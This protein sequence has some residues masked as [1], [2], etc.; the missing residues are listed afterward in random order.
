VRSP[1]GCDR[2]GAIEYLGCS[3]TMF[4]TV[5]RLG[6]VRSVRKG[7]YL[8]ADLD[9]AAERL[10]SIRDAERGENGEA[11]KGIAKKRRHLGGQGAGPYDGRTKEL[12]RRLG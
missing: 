5:S 7:W 12:L 6:V 4:E 11:T 10:R 9:A 3:Q 1:I 8:Y 2:A